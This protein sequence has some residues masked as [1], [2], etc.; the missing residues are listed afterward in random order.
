MET[1]RNSPP[2]P[3]ETKEEEGGIILHVARATKQAGWE[4]LH[5]GVSTAP[6]RNDQFPLPRA[7]TGRNPNRNL[8]SSRGEG[9]GGWGDRSPPM[10]MA[11][12]GVG[13]RGWAGDDMAMGASSGRSARSATTLRS[14]PRSD[15]DCAPRPLPFPSLPSFDPPAPNTH[16][17]PHLTSTYS[18]A[19]LANRDH[20]IAC[21]S[22][23]SVTSNARGQ[24]SR[25]RERET[26]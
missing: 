11:R 23:G 13:L 14:N 19:N 26:E 16:T 12:W 22:D 5:R 21:R 24:H 1:N 20:L 7:K 3:Q 15:S 8:E 6:N 10:S 17:P 2:H 18:M 25:D 4:N 9:G